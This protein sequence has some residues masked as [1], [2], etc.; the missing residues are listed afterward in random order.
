MMAAFQACACLCAVLFSSAGFTAGR[1]LALP[2]PRFFIYNPKNSDLI[3][4]DIIPAKPQAQRFVTYTVVTDQALVWTG[5]KV[6]YEFEKPFGKYDYVK[7]TVEEAM[8]YI[9]SRSCVKFE[10]RN[11]QENYINIAYRQGRCAS[12]VGMQGGEQTI[13]LDP[14]LC[15]DLGQLLHELLHALGFFHEHSRFDRDKYV[16]VHWD[17]IDPITNRSFE[18]KPETEADPLG[19]EYDY[20]SVMHYPH[21]AFSTKPDASTLTP[22]LEGVD[23]NALGEGYRDSFLTDTDIKKLN[24]LYTCGQQAP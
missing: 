12:N 4:G 6:F 17:N 18:L 23:V 5:G 13:A 10:K 15:P 14:S 24:I 16:T 9:Q 7:E 11:G 8:E 21:D 2:R 3:E 19:Q 22:I 1:P 20:K